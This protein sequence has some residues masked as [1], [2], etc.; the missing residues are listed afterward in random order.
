MSGLTEWAVVGW[1]EPRMI[2]EQRV[3]L[4]REM[5]VCA[6]SQETFSCKAEPNEP[7]KIIRRT[8]VLAE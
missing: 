7:Q 2:P 6:I 5:V 4:R 8:S 3:R 1:Y